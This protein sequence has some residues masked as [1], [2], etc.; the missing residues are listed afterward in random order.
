[1]FFLD[2][3]QSLL[4]ARLSSVNKGE[5]V[6]RC[7]HLSS[8]LWK[9]K[10]SS[11]QELINNINNEETGNSLN[12]L[13]K[14][15]HNQ[16][17]K[18]N[19]RRN[20]KVRAHQSK[21]NKFE[22]ASS[23]RGENFWFP[24]A[25]QKTN[26]TEEK[27]SELGENFDQDTDETQSVDN[28]KED[29]VVDVSSQN[30]PDLSIERNKLLDKIDSDDSNREVSRLMSAMINRIDQQAGGVEENLQKLI[31]SFSS[32]KNETDN[33]PR[34]RNDFNSK[35]S[36]STQRRSPIKTFFDDP[37]SLFEGLAE[38]KGV[39]QD[40]P[41]VNYFQSKW[42]D[43]LKDLLPQVKPRNAFEAKMLDIDREWQFPI[44]NEQ[45]M[46]IEETTG[47]DEHVFL[48]HLLDEFP[49]EGPVFKFMELV[50]TGLQQ[51]SHLSV[52]EKTS[53]VLWFK[54]YF[55]KFSDEDLKVANLEF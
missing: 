6:N 55:D 42:N 44:N 25:A 1:M 22:N 19:V 9:N 27:I 12:N 37:T 53:Q 38:S 17:T 33:R 20:E 21:M 45:D 26:E 47:F 4:R 18:Q 54:E 14:D 50:V 49:E 36:G 34:H 3:M 40:Y 13:V 28:V 35:R 39:D 23:K 7:Y 51:N 29:D 15:V 30:Q 10:K 11:L 48:D 32:A 5:I 43:E 8:S 46:G 52:E 16:K 2:I 41:S 31:K 24:E